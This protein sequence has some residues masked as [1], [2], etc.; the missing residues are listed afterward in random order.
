M[1]KPPTRVTTEKRKE[2]NYMKKLLSIVIC[3]FS[4]LVLCFAVCKNK[5]ATPSTPTGDIDINNWAHL[6]KQVVYESND[7]VLEFSYGVYK[8][9]KLTTETSYFSKNDDADAGYTACS[10]AVGRDGEPQEI[11]KTN[12]Q[13][14]DEACKNGYIMVIRKIIN[15]R[16][17]EPE[18][19]VQVYFITQDG[20]RYELSC[21]ENSKPTVVN[22]AKG[23]ESYNALNKLAK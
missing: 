19:N 7:T 11:S 15:T 8:T 18:A 13:V 3:I 1:T 10:I 20:K 22:L 6:S 14:Y 12:R 16:Y 23:A 9:P 21:F 17:E 2:E 5:T 4:I